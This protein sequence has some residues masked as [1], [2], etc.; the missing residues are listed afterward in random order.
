[1]LITREISIG[2]RMATRRGEAGSTCLS[3]MIVLGQ[4]QFLGSLTLAAVSPM[5]AS[6]RV[7]KSRNSCR[8]SARVP[9]IR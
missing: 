4:S 8:N 3:E 2:R 9:S 6:L 5:N 7:K 1:M